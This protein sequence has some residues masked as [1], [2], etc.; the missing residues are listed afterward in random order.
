MRWAS[1][2]GILTQVAP[3][4][5]C[6]SWNFHEH[7]RHIGPLRRHRQY[8][9]PARTEALKHKTAAEE[10]LFHRH[11]V[12]QKKSGLSSAEMATSGASVHPPAEQEPPPSPSPIV[13]RRKVLEHRAREPNA[14][15]SAKKRAGTVFR[16]VFFM[17]RSP[18]GSGVDYLARALRTGVPSS[19]QMPKPVRAHSREKMGTNQLRKA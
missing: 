15:P 16:R 14:P 9:T 3:V 13:A 12:A 1:F 6:P 5:S 2:P 4:F 11:P 7:R 19:L 17:T 18:S 10:K 8:C